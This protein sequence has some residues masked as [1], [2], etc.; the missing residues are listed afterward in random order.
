MNFTS[1]FFCDTSRNGEI[2]RLLLTSKD[3]LA[4]IMAGWIEQVQDLLLPNFVT[5]L[6]SS[7]FTAYSAEKTDI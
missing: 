1:Q 6:N 7:C 3:S 5:D 2:Q 4:A